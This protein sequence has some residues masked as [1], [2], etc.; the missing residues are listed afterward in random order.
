ML[1]PLAPSLPLSSSQRVGG[2][3]P[4]LSE[5]LIPV[6]QQS[7]ALNREPSIRLSTASLR[8]LSWIVRG[9]IAALMGLQAP[10]RC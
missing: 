1:P 6:E 5:I 4:A 7:D 10:R 3:F 2:S 8:T 9:S